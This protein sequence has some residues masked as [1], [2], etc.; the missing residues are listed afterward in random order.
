MARYVR[1]AALALVCLAGCQ[2]LNVEHAL[3][4]EAADAK[5]YFV[6][7]PKRDQSV[8]AKVTAGDTPVD[9]QLVVLNEGAP[10]TIEEVQK[11]DAKILDKKAQ[12]QDATLEG[13]VP[14]KHKFAVVVSNAKKS[15]RVIIKLTS[16]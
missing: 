10:E 6:D 1:A 12:T 3:Q 11:A 13:T 16:K 8:V 2:K 4:L 9:V 14:A 7:A 5:A 15:T